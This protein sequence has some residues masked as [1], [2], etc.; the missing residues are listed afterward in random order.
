[1]RR[2]EKRV[3]KLETEHQATLVSAEDSVNYARYERL[4]DGIF[5]FVRAAFPD[6]RDC[7]AAHFA[8]I[9]GLPDAPAFRALLQGQPLVDIAQDRYGKTWKP[10]MEAT[11]AAAAVHC[12]NAHGPEWPEKFLAIWCGGRLEPK[13]N[14]R[15]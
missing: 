5:A 13:C 8:Q 9:F 3:R 11:A 2:L 15:E 4:K 1:V 6:S 14:L 10:E 12:Q 7:M